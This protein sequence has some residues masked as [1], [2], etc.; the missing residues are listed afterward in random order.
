MIGS[1]NA[2]FAST[3]L[4]VVGH[5][6]LSSTPV[7]MALAG[8]LGETRYLV[9]YSA[10]M[11][12]A[13]VWMIFAFIEAP[14]NPVWP[15]PDVLLWVPVVLMPIAIFLIVGGLTTPSPTLAGTRLDDHNRDLT[16]GI[17]RITRHPFLNGVSLW[18]LAH[19]LVNGDTRSIILFAGMFILSAGGMWHIDKRREFHYGADW[20]P[21]MLTTSAV[22][23]GALLEKRTT[24][25]WAGIGWWRVLLSIAIY[26]ALI[27]GHGFVIGEPAWPGIG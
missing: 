13:M 11:L 22:P 25:D 8:W 26:L 27:A 7:R 20:G 18:A 15:T 14:A 5:F 4:L 6:A 24:M 17:I 10:A 1:L 2:L 9:A 23:F 19:L 16:R 12:A 3:V 21:V